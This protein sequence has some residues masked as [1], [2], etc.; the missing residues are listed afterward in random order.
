MADWEGVPPVNPSWPTRPESEEARKRRRP[1]PG[2]RPPPRREEEG[3]GPQGGEGDGKGP[4][5]GHIIDEY[6]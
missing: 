1:P 5:D 4:E 3:N 6:A 2:R